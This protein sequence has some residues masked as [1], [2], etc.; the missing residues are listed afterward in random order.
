VHADDDLFIPG[1]EYHH[2]EENGELYS[3]IPTGYVGETCPFDDAKADASPWL[4]ELPII[5]LF[6]RQILSQE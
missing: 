3:Q 6:K 2:L 1:Y 5:K 4:N